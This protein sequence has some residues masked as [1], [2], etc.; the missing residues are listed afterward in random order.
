[1]MHCIECG[2]KHPKSWYKCE[3]Y[4]QECLIKVKYKHYPST[5]KIKLKQLEMKKKLGK[6]WNKKVNKDGIIYTIGGIKKMAEET[7]TKPE[8]AETSEPEEKEESETE[9]STEE[10]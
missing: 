10:E 1:M 8:E 3:P 9:E 4:C 7:E 2:K 5:M 6:G